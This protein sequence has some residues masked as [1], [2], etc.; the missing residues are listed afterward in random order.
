[1]AETSTLSVK[2]I[3]HYPREA[4]VGKTY[5]MTVDLQP[6]NDFDWQYEEEEYEI[7][8]SVS[9]E[10]C[11][12]KSI[13]EPIITLHR[14]GGT[15]G[16]ARFLFLALQEEESSLQVTLTNR[17]GISIQTI[18]LKV[19]VIDQ[20]EELTEI[21][22]PELASILESLE[23]ESS[24]IEAINHP[25]VNHSDDFNINQSSPS[26]ALDN[27]YDKAILSYIR[28]LA[29]LDE[30]VAIEKYYILL[31]YGNASDKSVTHAIEKIVTASNFNKQSLNLIN[32]LY[33]T[34]VNPWHM[35][36]NKGNAIKKIILALENIPMIK[37][38]NNIQ[39]RLQ[40]A[41]QRY[42]VDERYSV[43]R[44]HMLLVDSPTES[45]NVDKDINP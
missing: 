20:V 27:Q 13:G 17:W 38:Q 10:T 2:P 23:V 3:I 12:C 24:K 22:Q 26:P 9:S 8:C 6:K 16:E 28:N 4:Q 15:Y 21:H 30:D 5:L 42:R 45:N 33:Y 34:L 41:L 32:R 44:K 39:R 31:L 14:F 43:L 18:E 7:Y 35:Q 19:A 1:M 29:K 11:T 36:P 37:T 25:L 40:D